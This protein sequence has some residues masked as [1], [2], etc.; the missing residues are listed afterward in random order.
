MSVG[1]LVGCGEP[2]QS[3]PEDDAFQKQLTDAAAKTNAPLPTK[4][5]EGGTKPP[6][7]PTKP[8]TPGGKAPATD[9]AK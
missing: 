9:T 6:A 8:T 4:G 1:M 5:K 2:A 3:G 7:I